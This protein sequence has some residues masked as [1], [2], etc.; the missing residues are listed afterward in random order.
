MSQPF[1]FIILDYPVHPKPRFGWN[2]PPHAKLY[3]II[4]RNRLVY[5][6]YLNKFLKYKDHFV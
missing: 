6:E 5:A 1:Y 2:K 3:E 4:N